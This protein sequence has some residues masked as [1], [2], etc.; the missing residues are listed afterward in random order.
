MKKKKSNLQRRKDNCGSKYW[1]N[2]ADKEWS[3]AIRKKY[4]GCVVCGNTPV[5]PHHLISR[6]NAATRHSIENGL[7]LCQ[8]HHIFDHKL[9]AHGAPLAFSEWLQLHHPETWQWCCDN[10]N[11]VE[12][13]DYKAAYYRLKELEWT[14]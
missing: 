14:N 3:Q 10:K 7:G 5:D 12:K 2:R 8:G 9:S 1:R 11:R 13:P 4:P 6:S